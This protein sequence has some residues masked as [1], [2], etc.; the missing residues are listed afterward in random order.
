MTT[1]FGDS[2]LVRDLVFTIKPGDHLMITG[3]N[4]SG[5][6]SIL[7]LLSGLWPLFQGH[8]STPDSIFYIPQRPYLSLGTLRDQIIYPN[9]VQ[10]MKA[11]GKT[12]DDLLAIL[13]TVFLDYIPPRE[14]GMDV[15]KEWKDVFSGGEK[16]RMQLA[17]LFYRQPK[18]VVLDEATSAVS[19]DVESLLYSAAKDAGITVITISHRPNLLNYHSFLLRIGEGNDGTQWEWSQVGTKQGLIESIESEIRKL[20]SR[21]KDTDSLRKRL[22]EINRELQLDTSKSSELQ[23]SKRTLV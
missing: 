14:G 16:Q 7:R 17:R 13:K 20:E 1:P 11:S 3:P 8:I 21:L 22:N 10:D 5:K 9:S 6:T 19:S 23:H 18:Y 2:V 15:V 4:G 12:D